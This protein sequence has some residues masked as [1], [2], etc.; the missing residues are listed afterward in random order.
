MKATA[1][2]TR[3]INVKIGNNNFGLNLSHM[4]MSIKALDL[5]ELI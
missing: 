1:K 5:R 2:I 3:K 4:I